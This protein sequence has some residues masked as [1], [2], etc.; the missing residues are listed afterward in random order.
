MQDEV[1]SLYIAI[2]I[3]YVYAVEKAYISILHPV[4]RTT[5]TWTRRRRRWHKKTEY[6]AIAITIITCI[7][8]INTTTKKRISSGKKVERSIIIKSS[9]FMSSSCSCRS[10]FLLVWLVHHD[11]EE[12]RWWSF[13]LNFP[14][15]NIYFLAIHFSSLFHHLIFLFSQAFLIFLFVILGT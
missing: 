4:T 9:S 13:S 5:W 6:S 7:L 15:E 14:C 12:T 11:T 10:L 8:H 1:V 2:I 3:Q